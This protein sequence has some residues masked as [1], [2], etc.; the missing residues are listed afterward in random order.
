MLYTSMGRSS[1][2]RGNES[3]YIETPLIH[4]KPDPMKALITLLALS[5]CVAAQ[6]Q[7]LNEGRSR[8]V[9]KYGGSPMYAP[10]LNF[11]SPAQYH[12]A[13]R[14]S[15]GGSAAPIR[16]S[17]ALWLCDA[18]GRVVGSIKSGM[19]Y[20]REGNEM[21][22]LREGQTRSASV[23]ITVALPSVFH[24]ARNGKWCIRTGQVLGVWNPDITVSSSPTTK[25][26]RYCTLASE[27]HDPLPALPLVPTA[28]IVATR[29]SVA[30]VKA[31]PPRGPLKICCAGRSFR[32]TEVSS[33]FVEPRW[34]VRP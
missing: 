20:D 7:N 30:Y 18:Q 22:T 26:M 23:G 1:S 27:D 33:I 14:Y 32:A 34:L 15:D 6:A 28:S 16:P 10:T 13:N 9:G 5:I 8:T 3:R 2:E 21:A 24:A 11:Q 12:T 29:R 19:I 17:G 25:D 31:I 4:P